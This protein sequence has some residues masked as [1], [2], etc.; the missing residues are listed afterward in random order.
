MTEKGEGR[1]GDTCDT[2]GKGAPSTNSAAGSHQSQSLT[3]TP[4]D[5]DPEPDA[6][7]G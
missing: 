3:P 7:A 2:G 5:H 1:I 6:Q 4:R